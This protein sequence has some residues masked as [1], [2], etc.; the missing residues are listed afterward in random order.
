MPDQRAGLDQGGGIPVGAMLQ[1]E[2]P[3]I[4]AAG[5]VAQH[6]HP[7]FGPIRVEHYDN[8]LKQGAAAARNMLGTDAVFD[9]THWFWSDQFEHNLQYVGFAAEWDRFVVRGSLEE[10][11]FVGFY[12]RDGVV[13]AVVGVYRGRDVRRAAGLVR[14]ARPVDL[15]AL[16]DEDVDLKKLSRSL[17]STD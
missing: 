2:I 3:G 8:A 10:R 17:A 11:R 13:K 5:D 7:I 12:V 16:Q 14:A 9:D 6:D 4:F 15:G 1:T